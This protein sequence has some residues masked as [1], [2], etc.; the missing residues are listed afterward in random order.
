MWREENSGRSL[1]SLRHRHL[2]LQLL[3]CTSKIAGGVPFADQSKSLGRLQ[4]LVELLNEQSIGKTLGIACIDDL[5]LRLELPCGLS[6]RMPKVTELGTLLPELSLLF[7]VQLLCHPQFR[8]SKFS[9]LPFHPESLIQV[10]ASFQQNLDVTDLIQDT[11][12]RR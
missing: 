3:L 8:S 6:E 12:G 5:L 1:K 10:L 4:P 7:L 2:V 9:P 11:P